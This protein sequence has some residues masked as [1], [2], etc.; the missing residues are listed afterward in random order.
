MTLGLLNL[1]VIDKALEL[2]N[3]NRTKEEQLDLNKIPMDDEL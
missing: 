1:S 3:R 2:I